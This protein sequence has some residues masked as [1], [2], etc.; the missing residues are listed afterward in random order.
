MTSFLVVDCV[1]KSYGA[2]RVLTAGSLRAECCQVRVLFGRNGSGKST[3]LKIAAGYVQPDS[4]VVH[5]RG[6]ARLRTSMARMARDGV[7]YLPDHD[8]LS[9]ALSL[10]QQLR[11]FEDRFT[12]RT[13]A[14]AAR[15]AMVESL[16]DRKPH[17]LSGGELRR[18]ELAAALT[19]RPH[20][21]LADEPFRGIAP[22]DHDAIGAIL[23]AMAAEGCAVV[24]TGHEVSSLLTFADHITWCT[25]GTTYE[26]GA[27]HEAREH[28]AF[29]N[30]YLGL[31]GV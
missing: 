19:R 23:Q 21:V 2:K 10:R 14:E 4:G 16:L 27:P 17:T 25:S 28:E 3:L 31:R 9:S 11:M 26:L 30:E 6:N 22:V 5:V 7:F 13:V 1:T 24:I 18:A 15:I 20:C 8:L 12:Q 29:A